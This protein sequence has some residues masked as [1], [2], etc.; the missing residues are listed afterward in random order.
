MAGSDWGHPQAVSR[1]GLRAE[2]KQLPTTGSRTAALRGDEPLDTPGHSGLE[3]TPADRAQATVC[4]PAGRHVD[5]RMKDA[6]QEGSA[7]FQTVGLWGDAFS[8]GSV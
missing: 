3:R 5:S 6:I 1:P 7:A 2:R 8:S 4:S